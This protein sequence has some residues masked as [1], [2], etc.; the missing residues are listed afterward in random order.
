[1][2]TEPMGPQSG[3]LNEMSPILLDIWILGSQLVIL[4]QEHLGDVALLEKYAT[5][6]GLGI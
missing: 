6:A 5:G 1:M 3:G 4:I 2:T